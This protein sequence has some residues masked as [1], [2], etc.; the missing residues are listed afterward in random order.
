MRRI[1]VIGSIVLLF[2]GYWAW[3]RYQSIFQAN[4]TIPEGKT[5]FYIRSKE[6]YDVVEQRLLESGI[7]D[8]VDA[9]LWTAEMKDYPN[10]VKPGRYV[11]EDGMSS[12]ELVNLL[13]SGAQ[14]PVKVTFN[15]VRGLPALAGKVSSYL[16]TDSLTLLRTMMNDSLIRHYGF[17]PENFISMFVPDSYEL[18]WTISPEEFIARMA[19]GFKSYWT[20]ER[21]SKAE[22]LGLSQS[23]V[24]TLASIVQAEQAFVKEEWPTIAG[25][26]LNRLKKGIALQSDPTVIFATGDFSIRRVLTQHTRV[27]SPYN[28]YKYPGLPPGPIRMPDQQAVD[29]VLNAQ[30]HDFIF[31]CAHA[32][33]SGRHH[34]SKTLRE[35]NRYA[36]QYRNALNRKGVYR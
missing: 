33:L 2:G 24:V 17:I 3:T 35:H 21:L 7:L 15:N 12:N 8:D 29:A 34:F 6:D 32:D 16:E 25:L 31:M 26:Y 20:S 19:R 5:D 4:V 23:Q 30:N 14:T 28:T 27:D 36:A 1:I 13:R 22:A 10:L 11:L 18:Y 9:F